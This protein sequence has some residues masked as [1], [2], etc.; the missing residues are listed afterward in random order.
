[1]EQS[2]A[3]QRD[4]LQ[5][6]VGGPARGRPTRGGT[7]CWMTV[8]E[9]LALPVGRAERQRV[10][11]GPRLDGNPTRDG[12]CPRQ[13]PDRPGRPAQPT[14]DRPGLELRRAA[15]ATTTAAGPCCGGLPWETYPAR[16][17]AR[18][19]APDRLGR[20]LGDRHADRRHR[21]RSAASSTTTRPDRDAS[22]ASPTAPATRSSSARSCPTRRPTATS[23]PERRDR[24]HD[25]PDQLELEHRPGQRRQL[26]RELAEPR[27]RWAAASAPPPRG[28]RA[29]TPAGQL[30]L[31]R[32]LGQVPQ[33]DHQPGDL[34]RPGQPQRRRG[35]QRRRL[36]TDGPQLRPS[37]SRTEPA[38]AGRPSCPSA[39]P[40][41]SAS[42]DRAPRAPR[43]TRWTSSQS[44]P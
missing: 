8:R 29:S 31:R 10:P 26:Q 12:Q 3:L 43:R 39:I 33:A 37:P 14:T 41:G 20:L 36:L 42:E 40:P 35:H 15:S 32:R 17:A 13:H 22:P 16:H 25:R 11:P 5:I 24:R 6:R 21:Q 9:H 44:V 4:Q 18:R 1:M 30:P 2:N 7:R 38:R 27:P 34:L 23:G 19:P 28:S